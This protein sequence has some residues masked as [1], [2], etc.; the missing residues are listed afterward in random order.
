V[1]RLISLLSLIFLVTSFSGCAFW[2]GTSSD[3][4]PVST[5]PKILTSS[6]SN[7]I[8]FAAESEG[9]FCVYT[10]DDDVAG[11]G[12]YGF[13]NEDGDITS[14]DYDYACPFSEGLALVCRDGK[15]GFIDGTGKEVLPLIYDE[16]S[17]FHE[18]LAYFAIGDEY[19]FMD[20]G[21]NEV[22]SLDCDSVSSFNEGLAYFSV[23]GKYGYMD[24]TGKTII[25]AQY[26]DA[27]YFNNGLATVRIGN[28]F[29]VI[30]TSGKEVVSP[31]YDETSI[32]ADH[33]FFITQTG[34]KYGC[35]NSKGKVI[36]PNEYDYICV[37]NSDNT[38]IDFQ[39]NDKSGLADENGNIILQPI[40]DWIEPLPGKSE[41]MVSLDG[42]CGIISYDGKIQMPF[43]YDNLIIS[44]YDSNRIIARL[45]TDYG[46]IDASGKQIIPFDY[47]FIKACDN[48][49]ILE[50]GAQ[51]I[52]ADENGNSITNQY[53]TS[54]LQLGNFFEVE[55]GN[56]KYGLIDRNGNEVI[57]PQYDNIFSWVY[58][59]NNCVIA[60]KYGENGQPNSDSIIIVGPQDDADLSDLILENEITPKIKQFSDFVKNGKIETWESDVGDYFTP[61]FDTMTG[62]KKVFKLYDM[63]GSGVPILYF[64]AE[65]Y[66]QLGFLESYSGFFAIDGDGVNALMTGYECGG[67]MGGNLASCYWDLDNSKIALG[68]SDHW[69]GFGGF[70]DGDTIYNYKNGAA[71]EVVSYEC[72]SQTP[73][74]YDKSDLLKNA[75]LFYDDDGNPYNKSTIAQADYVNEYQVNNKR[76]SIDNYNKVVNRYQTVMLGL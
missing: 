60:M 35:I 71:N 1:K 31:I 70:L 40:Y 51:S 7:K 24:K 9:I 28:K 38:K 26:D 16:A 36:M 64:D 44:N 72:I 19:G 20:E 37:D 50:N 59:S 41:A 48:G 49:L 57:S 63:D 2:G 56:Y 14:F 62:G 52:L 75:K 27:G 66:V 23:N 32:K 6:A 43:T 29:G 39:L 67:S 21:G 55:D 68:V 18:G 45:G 65:P 15:Y 46:V 17:S 25:P 4:S 11:S 76:V 5:Y 10:G 33:G 54:I 12:K 8:G 69:G 47:S 73:L 3:V 13:M 61:S 30:D 58:N 22:F 42:K 53:Y 34:G 74:N